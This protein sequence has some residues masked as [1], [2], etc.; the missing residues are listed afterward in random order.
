M[1]CEEVSG[2]S[3]SGIEGVALAVDVVDGLQVCGQIEHR[4]DED[5]PVGLPLDQAAQ[6]QIRCID[7]AEVSSDKLASTLFLSAHRCYGWYFLIGVE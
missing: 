1:T 6:L 4:C 5:L 7:G 2:R 3:P